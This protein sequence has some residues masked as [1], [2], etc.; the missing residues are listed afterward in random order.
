MTTS[1]YI[2][3]RALYLASLGPLSLPFACKDDSPCDEG[4]EERNSGCYPVT[5]GGGAAGAT[6]AGGAAST[7]ND[8]GSADSGA[9]APA[10]VE[11]EVGQTC[12]DTTASSDCGGAAPICAPLPAGP[13]CTQIL[14]LP[15]EPNAGACPTGWTCLQA[16]PLPDPSVCLNF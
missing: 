11:A 5:A 1:K 16:R 13:V 2:L 8:G 9:S 14:C 15:G 7:D 6:N 10:G 12:A 3:A 4:Q